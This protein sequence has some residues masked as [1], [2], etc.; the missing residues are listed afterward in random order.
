MVAVQDVETRDSASQLSLPSSS[1]IKQFM[2]SLIIDT[3][4]IP[5]GSSISLDGQSTIIGPRFKGFSQIPKGWH[6]FSYNSSSSTSTSSEPS[7]TSS[8]INGIR[9]SIL[10]YFHKDEIVLR[11]WDSTLEMIQ[12]IIVSSQDSSR[13]HSLTSEQL[14]SYRSMLA[15]Y[16]IHDPSNERK[17]DLERIKEIAVRN[18]SMAIASL[19]SLG[20][21][22]SR[23]LVKRIFGPNSKETGFDSFSG[24]AKMDSLSEIW[25]PLTSQVKAEES[26]TDPVTSSDG[27]Q[28]EDPINNPKLDSQGRPYWGIA[29]PQDDSNSNGNGRETLEEEEDGRPTGSLKFTDFDLKRS[30]SKDCNGEERTR[31]SVDKS[32]LLQDVIERSGGES[33]DE[34][35]DEASRLSEIHLLILIFRCFSILQVHHTY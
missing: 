14:A 2:A 3:E 33:D 20:E 26:R 18:W 10:R 16:P 25:S 24:D 34:K 5:S 17:E 11:K 6:L 15:P 12:P 29:R 28:T 19:N 1:S 8:G 32:W 22:E 31:W 21:K 9:H 23:K 13:P 35:A 30:W 7:I 27:T 4:P